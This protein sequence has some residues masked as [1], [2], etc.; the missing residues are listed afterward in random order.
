[1]ISCTFP[2]ITG[3]PGAGVLAKNDIRK[4]VCHV[5]GRNLRGKQCFSQKNEVQH[6]LYLCGRQVGQDR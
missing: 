4:P 5:R 6:I 1:M 3:N 2:K